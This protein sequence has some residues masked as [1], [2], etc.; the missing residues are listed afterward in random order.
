MRQQILMA[1]SALIL[2]SQ[3]RGNI[4]AAFRQTYAPN[5][6]RALVPCTNRI[7]DF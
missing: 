5:F 4:R 1:I 3:A 7:L 2:A 6:D